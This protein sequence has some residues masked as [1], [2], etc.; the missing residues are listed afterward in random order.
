MQQN[1]LV[2]DGLRAGFPT[3]QI[4]GIPDSLDPESLGVA[5]E[6]ARFMGRASFM[7]VKAARI[8]ARGSSSVTNGTFSALN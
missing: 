6:E 5:K 8:A 7:A 3:C 1:P 4:M 2:V